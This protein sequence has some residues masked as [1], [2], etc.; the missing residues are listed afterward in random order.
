[1]A[2]LHLYPLCNL[3]INALWQIAAITDIYGPLQVYFCQV[4]LQTMP[5]L[6]SHVSTEHRERDS[7]SSRVHIIMHF[8]RRNQNNSK[9]RNWKYCFWLG[10][11]HCFSGFLWVSE[12]PVSQRRT[13]RLQMREFNSA[14]SRNAGR[15]APSREIDTGMGHNRQLITKYPCSQQWA[16]FLGWSSCNHSSTAAGAKK[17]PSPGA[18]SPWC[19]DFK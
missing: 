5:G 11:F 2:L 1:M 15:G 10:K 6:C 14:L 9:R 17:G 3:S 16:L 18:L 4:R 7:L 12:L 19:R 8:L 13:L